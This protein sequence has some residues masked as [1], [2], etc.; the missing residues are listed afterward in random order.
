MIEKHLNKL[1]WN[2]NTL[3]PLKFSYKDFYNQENIQLLS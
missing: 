3:K 2:K 1:W